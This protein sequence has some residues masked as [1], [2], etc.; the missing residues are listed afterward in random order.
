[1]FLYRDVFGRQ[2]GDFSEYRRARVHPHL[3][4]WL[5]REE[6]QGLFGC[7][8]DPARLMARL[9]GVADIRTIQELLG[10]ED[11]STAMIYTHVLRQGG[12]GMRSPLDRLWRPLSSLGAQAVAGFLT[13]S[14]HPYHPRFMGRT[15]GRLVQSPNVLT[16]S[17]DREA[18]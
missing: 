14:Q 2:L 8:D 3:L 10:H 18:P 1:M 7:L 17:Q 15:R 12:A 5:T 13:N 9:Q 11:V 4:V 6:I 16:F